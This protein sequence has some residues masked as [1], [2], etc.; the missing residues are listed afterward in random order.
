MRGNERNVVHCQTSRL[1]VRSAAKRRV[2]NHGPFIAA[3]FQTPR[4]ARLLWMR[5]EIVDSIVKQPSHFSPH[6]EE[7]PKRRVSNHEPFIAPSFETPRYARLLRMRSEIVDSIVKQPSH[8][9]PHGE[10]RRKAARL[11]P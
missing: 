1:M 11:E 3:S 8:F 9:P 7:R 10:E 4:Y 2:S 6:G 5:S